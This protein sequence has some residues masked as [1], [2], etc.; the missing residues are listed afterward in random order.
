MSLSDRLI[1]ALAS[2]EKGRDRVER[3]DIGDCMRLLGFEGE[4]LSGV[5]IALFM[6]EGPSRQGHGGGVHVRE[7][8]LVV[9]NGVDTVPEGMVM[10][11]RAIGIITGLLR[12]V[13]DVVSR[14]AQ[15][16]DMGWKREGAEVAEGL[17]KGLSLAQLWLPF[18][19]E[20]LTQDPLEV[21]I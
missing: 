6:C 21:H 17:L 10:L 16:G 13:R 9:L 15:S 14:H 20:G 11:V 18:A 4:D 5:A 1:V 19:V 12:G 2:W 3:A 7:D 8:P